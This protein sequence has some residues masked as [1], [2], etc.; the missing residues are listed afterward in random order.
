MKNG[1]EH[2]FSFPGYA[3]LS[4][5]STTAIKSIIN[6]P[7]LKE[8]KAGTQSKTFKARA[9]TEA[10]ERYCSLS[11]WLLLLLFYIY[12]DYLLQESTAHKWASSPYQSLIKKM[13]TQTWPTGQSVRGIFSDEVPSSKMALTGSR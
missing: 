9:E 3:C 7:S 11:R 1:K 6:S 8:V 12:Q 13:L 5:L 2:C 10:V 4:Q